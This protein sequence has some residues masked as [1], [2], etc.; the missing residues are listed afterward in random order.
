MSINII[1]D[2]GATQTTL[3]LIK[4]KTDNLDIT[5]SATLQKTGTSSITRVSL[6]T[7]STTLAADNVNRKRIVIFN[8]GGQSI[9]LKYGLATTPT[10][11]TVKIASGGGWEESNYTG[12]ITARTVAATSQIQITEL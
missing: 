5:T 12:V 11:Y 2:L 4:A 10:S 9:Y 3:A 8:E 7:T 1:P 6:T